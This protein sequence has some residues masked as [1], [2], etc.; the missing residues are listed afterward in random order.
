MDPVLELQGAI[1]QRLRSYA[2][3]VAL[4]GQRS[5][6]N[7]PTDDKGQVAPSIFPYVSI[8]PSSAEQA[9]ADCIYADDI[10][11]QLDV[12]SLQPAQ[13][14]MR[15]IVDAVRK[16]LRGWDPSFAVNALVTFEYWRTDYIKD[17][18]INHASIRYTATVEQP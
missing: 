2:P 12:W 5:Y 16:A 17:G 18:N 6:D 4:V 15:D 1:I 11:F 9:N 10:V 7:P 13:K 8:G 3:L 14:Q